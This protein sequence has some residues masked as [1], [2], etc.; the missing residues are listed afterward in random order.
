VLQ[1]D[2]GPAGHRREQHLDRHGETWP[3]LARAVAAD[4]GWPTIL[5]QYAAA[6]DLPPVRASIV[7]AAPVEKAWRVYTEQY[8]SWYPKGHF[9][10]DGPAETV[11]IEP[12]AGGRWYEKQPDG[13]E[14]EWG[15]V[16]TWQPPHRLVLSWTIGADWKPDPDPAH[17]SEVEVLFSAVAGGTRV[18]LEHRYLGRLGDAAASIHDGVSHPDFGHP[19]YLRRFAAA[20]EGRPVG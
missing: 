6:L 4:G 2:P 14:P 8:G 19:Y 16:L 12:H 9:L 20:A 18:D 17:W 3:A 13:S 11:V 10:G 5:H 7:V 1:V 15:R